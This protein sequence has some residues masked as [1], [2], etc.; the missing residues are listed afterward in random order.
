[1]LS[2]NLTVLFIVIFSF[3]LLNALVLQTSFSPDEYWQSLEIAHNLEYGFGF[4]T[5]EWGSV[6]LRSYFH[7]MIFYILFKFLHIFNLDSAEALILFPRILESLFASIT[8]LYTILLAHKIF[9]SPFGNQ[10]KTLEKDD[11]NEFIIEKSP[12]QYSSSYTMTLLILILSNGFHF[13]CSTRTFSNCIE[14]MLIIIA[15]LHEEYWIIL[16]AINSLLRP[17]CVLF[18]IPNILM[19]FLHLN[20]CLSL[21]STL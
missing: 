6:A 4:K 16:T 13:Y 18:W 7:P 9:E 5:W 11:N 10:Q 15:L 1:M 21:L 20:S 2:S 3:R 19:C 17:T 12:D 14:T 8:D